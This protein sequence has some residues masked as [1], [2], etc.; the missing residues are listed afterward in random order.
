MPNNT[1]HQQHNLFGIVWY[2]LVF[3][4]LCYLVLF[5]IIWYY[6]VYFCNIW[7]YLVLVG[8]I[9]FFLLFCIT[10]YLILFVIIW[11]YLA[12]FGINIGINWYCL[13]N[14]CYYCGYFSFEKIVMN[15]VQ[16]NI[17]K[18]WKNIPYKVWST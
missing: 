1:K 10:W 9:C 14:N 2:Y 8:I 17:G 15:L 3:F 16:F 7:N 5:S 12:Y 6:F 18:A 11:Y 4:F 13:L